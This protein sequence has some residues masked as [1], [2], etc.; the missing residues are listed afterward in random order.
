MRCLRIIKGGSKA[1]DKYPHIEYDK[2]PYIIHNY[3]IWKIKGGFSHTR[4]NGEL[5][6]G[7]VISCIIKENIAGG[8]GEHSGH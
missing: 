3:I 7:W 5:G 2:Y 1:F 8:G 4:H 6:R